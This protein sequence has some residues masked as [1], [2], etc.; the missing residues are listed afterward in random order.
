M[1]RRLARSLIAAAVLPLASPPLRA[2][3]EAPLTIGA[4]IQ[5]SSH[6]M[7]LRVEQV[8]R[9]RNLILYRKVEDLKGK[10]PADLVKHNIG[11]GGLRPGEWQEIMGWAEPGKLAVF[12]H[13]GGASETFMG[14]NWYQAYAGGEWWNMSHAE[15]YLL[16]SFAGK[17]EKLAAAV[18]D[19]LA[20][21][22][23]VVPCMADG[24]KDDLHA[25]RGRI[26]RLRA[27][28]KLQDY[29]PKRDFAGWGGDDLRRVAGMPGFS[30]LAG[31]TRME[32]GAQAIS[33]ADFDG[34][35]R[36]DVCLAGA[37]NVA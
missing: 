29:N 37:R 1:T 6:V 27:S 25:K 30:H 23:V 2:Y 7:V 10:H 18:R 35:G 5:Q 28:L 4:V 34:D 14:P 9:E 24:S 16:R 12:F 13:N 19:I 31:L 3:V 33:F 20:G 32:F 36:L 11:R 15:P 26:Q 22:E 8:D 21:R 17:P